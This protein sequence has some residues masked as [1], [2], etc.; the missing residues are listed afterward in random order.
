MKLIHNNMDKKKLWMWIVLAVVLIVAVVLYF[1]VPPFAYATG[2]LAIGFC[3]G[4][5]IGEK[6]YLTKKTKQVLN[7]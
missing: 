5:I 7:D 4:H 3:I 2:G 6:G 1:T